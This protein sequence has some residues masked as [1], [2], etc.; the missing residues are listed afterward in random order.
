MDSNTGKANGRRKEVG[1]VI[2]MKGNMKMIRRKEK[3]SSPGQVEIFTKE[4]MKTMNEM[5]MER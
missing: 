4:S 5:D 2:H 1:I 3:E